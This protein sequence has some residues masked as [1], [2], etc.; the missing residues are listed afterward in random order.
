[1]T[2]LDKKLKELRISPGLLIETLG[3]PKHRYYDSIK[4]MVKVNAVLAICEAIQAITGEYV[5]MDDIV[6]RGGK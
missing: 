5:A 2:K 6:D 4:P 3:V 1:M